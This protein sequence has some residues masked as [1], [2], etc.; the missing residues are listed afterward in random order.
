MLIKTLSTLF[1][2]DLK[3]LHHEIEMYQNEQNLWRIDKNI[4]NS[5]GNLTLHL[6]GNLN[7]Y[8]GSIL[9]NTTYIRNRENEF[10][11]KNIPRNELL[12][13]INET[14]EMVSLV[15]RNLSESEL[16]E[17]YPIL[18]FEEKTST[19]FLLIHLST[20]LTYHLGQINYHRRLLDF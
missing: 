1:V 9:G 4:L 3:K 15:I 5:A 10:S 16:N 2:R 18:V 7:T 12:L 20:H 13:K 8:I 19:Q 6:I 11:L 14:I 17:E